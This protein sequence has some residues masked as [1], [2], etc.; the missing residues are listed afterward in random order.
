VPDKLSAH[1]LVYF[2]FFLF[3][4]ARDLLYWKSAQVPFPEKGGYAMAAAKKPV[5]K[6]TTK[7]A[8]KPAAKKGK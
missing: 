7:S 8:K 6:K 2:L 5:S 1:P 3:A 4:R